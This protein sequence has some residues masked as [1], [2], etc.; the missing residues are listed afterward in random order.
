MALFKKVGS[1]CMALL[2]CASFAACNSSDKDTSSFVP[3]DRYD[4]EQNLDVGDGNNP[5]KT[6]VDWSMEDDKGKSKKELDEVYRARARSCLPRVIFI[7]DTRYQLAVNKLAN[8]LAYNCFADLSFYWDDE[9]LYE[10]ELTDDD[11]KFVESIDLDTWPE[12]EYIPDT[13]MPPQSFLDEYKKT[14]GSDW[15]DDMRALY[16]GEEE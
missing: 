15:E 1:L 9:R 3:S 10:R 8:E 11:M 13:G 7:D 2:L 5:E 12:G 16:I 4:E 6:Y 14:A